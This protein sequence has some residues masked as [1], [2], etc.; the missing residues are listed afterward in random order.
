MATRKT[1][2]EKAA[3]RWA[4][5]VS[6]VEYQIDTFSRQAGVQRE[7]GNYSSAAE[8]LTQAASAARKLARLME[9]NPNES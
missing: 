1:E 2:S 9:E 6:V 4:D 7:Q 3:A 8:L 5:K